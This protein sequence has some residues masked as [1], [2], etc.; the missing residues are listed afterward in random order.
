MIGR[1][2]NELYGGAY[3]FCLLGVQ[4][5]SINVESYTSLFYRDYVACWE[6]KHVK[7]TPVED[8]ENWRFFEMTSIRSLL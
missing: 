4:M 2:T 3:E 1:I 7:L 6:Y 5:R 8:S